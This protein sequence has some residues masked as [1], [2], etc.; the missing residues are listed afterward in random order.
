[1]EVSILPFDLVGCVA[2][3][4]QIQDM[5][6]FRMI[7]LLRLIKLLRLLRMSRIFAH[8]RDRYPFWNR[9]VAASTPRHLMLL[10]CDHGP[11]DCAFNRP[12]LPHKYAPLRRSRGRSG[13]TNG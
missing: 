13:R 5:K 2:Q 7:R 12:I 11:G 8:L 6:T 1:M 10:P 9:T 3:S 4:E